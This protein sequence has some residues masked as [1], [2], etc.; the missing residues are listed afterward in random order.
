AR[1]DRS[2]LDRLR[3][4][5]AGEG[6]VGGRRVG[7]ADFLGGA[8]PPSALP[9]P[10]P[11]PTAT[12]TLREPAW[13]FSLA[14]LAEGRDQ[15]FALPFLKIPGRGVER[16]FNLLPAVSD[17]IVFVTDSVRLFGLDL[18]SGKP[19]WE[20]PGA[21]EW[22]RTVHDAGTFREAPNPSFVVAPCADRGV[23]A[24]ALQVPLRRAGDGTEN[25]HRIPI[26]HI[27]PARRLFAFDS[28]TGAPLWTHWSPAV[29][30]LDLGSF[31]E[32]ATVAAPPVTDG[33]RLYTLSVLYAGKIDL[34][35][36]AYDLR[37][38]APVWRTPLVFGYI[39]QNMFGRWLVEYAGSPPLLADGALY[40]STNLGWVARLDASS[41]RIEWLARYEMRP[42]K[43]PQAYS[44]PERK[45]MWANRA[46]VLEGETLYTT[47]LDSRYL[48]A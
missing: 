38:G 48:F 24:A 2:T 47:P 23:V 46:P 16:P 14:P 6:E 10:L 25:F 40:V 5:P 22:G 41:G 15:R 34:Y 18:H 26:R 45:P 39:Q 7:V 33:E 19:R 12:A 1:G 11:P 43:K 9:N 37:T 17:G 32:R 36:C 8:S 44:E 35:A 28:A 30:T 29:A 13:S 31:H 4:A 27:L 42:Q 3:S 21:E 20:F